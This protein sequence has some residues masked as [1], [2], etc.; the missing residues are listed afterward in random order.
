MVQFFQQVCLRHW[1][2]TVSLGAEEDLELEYYKCDSTVVSR[3]DLVGMHAKDASL[4]AEGARTL[5]SLTM[6]KEGCP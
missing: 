2:I 5:N 4:Q 3:S 1:K 6:W